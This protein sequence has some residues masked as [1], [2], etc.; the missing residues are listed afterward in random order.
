MVGTML[1]W[2]AAER[3]L[4]PQARSRQ[5]LTAHVL[6]RMD[7]GGVHVEGLGTL[8]W[9]DLVSYERT[10]ARDQFQ[11]HTDRGYSLSVVDRGEVFEPVV[12]HYFAPTRLA[13]QTN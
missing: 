11:L 3:L 13:S 10:S 2:I 12:L 7:E 9:Q 4:N 8:P 6:M 1:A 5:T